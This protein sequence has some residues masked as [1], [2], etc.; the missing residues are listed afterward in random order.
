LPDYPPWWNRKQRAKMDALP[1]DM[2]QATR[3]YKAER[4]A[5]GPQAFTHFVKVTDNMDRAM[6]PSALY[7]VP[8]QL[9]DVFFDPH[10]S[11][12]G[13][14]GADTLS[15]HLYTNG[16]KPYWQNNPPMPNSFVA[17][18]CAQIGI[19]PDASL[20]DEVCDIA[21]RGSGAGD[22]PSLIS[23]AGLETAHRTIS[24][25]EDQLQK[26]GRRAR[27]KAANARAD[28]FLDG[29]CG[30]L[31]PGDVAIDLGAHMGDVSAKLLATGAD[32]I[33][34]DPAPDAVAQI[35]ER[36]G[37]HPN[38]TFYDKA[39]GLEEGI[40]RNFRASSFGI[41]DTSPQDG[42]VDVKQ[43][44]F[45]AFIKDIIAQRGAVAFLKVDI[46]GMELDLLE[47]M[48]LEDLFKDIRCVAVKTYQQKFQ[49]LRPRFRSL[50][51]TFSAHYA[52]SHVNL[53]W[54]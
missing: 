43:I 50:R 52:P 46:E 2:P 3:I 6:S 12:E 35:S 53:D 19:D 37:E 13:W 1:T 14:M 15:V 36:L 41:D 7:P 11:V 21:P 9:V 24:D 22:A 33:G 45:I 54:S 27:R 30:L 40:V 23:S 17:R 51:K 47:K 49:P 20:R 16:I 48:H 42:G 31:K 29:V 5:F 39:A 28:G 10:G 38:Y 18:M 44:D 25:L 32:V 8:F 34:F 4:T 26:A